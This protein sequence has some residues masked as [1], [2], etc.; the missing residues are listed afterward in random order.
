MG[1]VGALQ[2]V[3]L[4]REFALIGMNEVNERDG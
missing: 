3:S 2:A 4:M 1:G